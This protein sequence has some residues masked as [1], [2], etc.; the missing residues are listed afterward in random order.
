MVEQVS[1]IPY[2]NEDRSHVVFTSGGPRHFY[3][4]DTGR[5]YGAP[6]QFDGFHRAPYDPNPIQRDVSFQPGEQLEYNPSQRTQFGGEGR[7]NLN[8]PSYNSQTRRFNGPLSPAMFSGFRG[9]ILPQ[10]TAINQ[11]GSLANNAVSGAV[12]LGLQSLVN[13]AQVDLGAQQQTGR[14]QLALSGLIGQQ[15]AAERDTN[16]A[17]IGTAGAVTQSIVGG[18]LGGGNPFL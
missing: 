8:M 11:I 9:G 17:N 18:V 13:R 15:I 4:N 6:E 2:I 5:L 12:S 3:D 16:V 14:V 10:T 1:N 7:V